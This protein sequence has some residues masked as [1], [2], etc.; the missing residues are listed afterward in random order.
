MAPK[1]KER[2][3]PTPLV[4]INLS[5]EWSQWPCSCC[6]EMGRE[7]KQGRT[8]S[9]MS[10]VFEVNHLKIKRTHTDSVGSFR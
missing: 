1:R 6:L 8:R 4:N 7:E 3:R 9:N 2:E 10:E 5:P